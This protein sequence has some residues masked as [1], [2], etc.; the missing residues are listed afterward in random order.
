[1]SAIRAILSRLS[2]F[3]HRERRDRELDEEL[4]SHL[5]MQIEDNLR[6]GT[7]ATLHGSSAAAPRSPRSPCCCW[8]S[9][10]ARTR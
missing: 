3:L 6:C 8:R 9:A 7:S 10:S 5:Q 4:A 2:G 1:M